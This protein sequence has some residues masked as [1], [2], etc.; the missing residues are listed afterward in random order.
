MTFLETVFPNYI[1]LL[2]KAACSDR[3]QPSV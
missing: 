1:Y 3:P 2:I